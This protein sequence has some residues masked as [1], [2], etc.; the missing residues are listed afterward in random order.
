M[1]VSIAVHFIESEGAAVQQFAQSS[2]GRFAK[3][4]FLGAVGGMRFGRI[5][6]GDPV[7]VARELEGVAINDAITSAAAATEAEVRRQSI[8]CGG[9]NREFHDRCAGRARLRPLDGWRHAEHLA[10]TRGRQQ[11]PKRQASFGAAA[12]RATPTVYRA[13][14][15]GEMGRTARHIASPATRWSAKSRRGPAAMTHKGRYLVRR[16]VIIDPADLSSTVAHGA[17]RGPSS[18]IPSSPSSPSSSSS[19]RSPR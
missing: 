10:D 3:R 16:G 13:G 2:G 19:L 14:L 1:H 11:Q 17:P 7:L 8:G 5:D 15:S 12:I 4:R 6:I 18:S 9:G